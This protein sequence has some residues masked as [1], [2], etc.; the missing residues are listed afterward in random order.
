MIRRRALGLLAVALA[1]SPFLGTAQQKKARRIG[2]LALIP[3]SSFTFQ[4][5]FPAALAALSADPNVVRA[6][7]L[8]RRLRL[9]EPEEAA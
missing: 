7:E 5:D 2:V 1:M 6:T 4:H 9:R 3:F 8:Q